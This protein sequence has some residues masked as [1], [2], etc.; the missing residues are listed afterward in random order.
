[1]TQLHGQ[2]RQRATAHDARS[3]NHRELR[4]ALPESLPN[5]SPVPAECASSADATPGVG[6]WTCSDVLGRGSSSRVSLTDDVGSWASAG[7]LE[8][9]V[10]RQRRW[11]LN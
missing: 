2:A 1:M 7:A 8:F 4:T 10:L 11:G 6:G 5:V 9:R 3:L